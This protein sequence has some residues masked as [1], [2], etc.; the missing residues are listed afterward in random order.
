MQGNSFIIFC[1]TCNATLRL[2][3]MLRCIK[4]SNTSNFDFL[5]YF[6]PE[7]EVKTK[8]FLS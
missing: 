3:L 5:I 7:I 4:S 8:I 6:L 1:S 2:A